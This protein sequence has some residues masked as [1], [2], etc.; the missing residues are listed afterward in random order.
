MEYAEKKQ[1]KEL[2]AREKFQLPKRIDD[3]YK[4][5][6]WDLL[7]LYMESISFLKPKQQMEIKAI[8][9]Y[10]KQMAHQNNSDKIFELFC[11]MMEH[12]VLLSHLHIIEDKLPIDGYAVKNANLFRLRGYDSNR[13]YKRKDIFHM[14]MKCNQNAGALRYNIAGFP[15]LY[16]GSTVYGCCV[17]MGKGEQDKLMGSMFRL[18]EDRKEKLYIVDL[19]VRPMDYI[20]YVN[21]DKTDRRNY[22]YTQYL[23]V[24]PLIAACSFIAADKNVPY[25]KEYTISNALY[26]WLYKTHSHDICGIRYFSCAKKEYMIRSEDKV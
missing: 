8:C 20:K 1:F 17:E 19:G 3:T 21:Y 18:R 14:P 15:S 11:K 6:L 5:S 23:Y 25:I 9:D 13:N 16:L 4:D 12:T 26:R 22:T 24:Y 7:D 10:L 2:M